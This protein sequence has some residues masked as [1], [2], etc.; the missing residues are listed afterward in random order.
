MTYSAVEDVYE[1]V[2]TTTTLNMAEAVAVLK[3]VQKKDL[4][5][6]VC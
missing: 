5:E 4:F 2:L 3:R 1:R 6:F